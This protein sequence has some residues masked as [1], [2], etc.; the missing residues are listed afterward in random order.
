MSA[1]RQADV[2]IVGA[3]LA[4]LSAALEL[5]RHGRSVFVLEAQ[6]R[7]GGRVLSETRDGIVIDYGAQWISPHQKRIHALLQKYGLQAA[8]AYRAGNALFAL[9]GKQWLSRSDMPKLPLAARLDLYRLRRKLQ[10]M[11]GRI[12]PAAPWTAP[13]A[14]RLDAQ[15][16]EVWLAK[17]TLT[18]CG[19]AFV[20]VMAEEGLC[21]Q[22]SEVS[23]LDLLWNIA[24]A[25]GMERISTGE[26]AS[27]LGGAQTLPVRMAS[28]LG[29][30][31]RLGRPVRRI[32][33]DA[34]GVA[35]YTAQGEEW[36]GRAAIV[37]MP[38]T[39]A[40]R[41]EYDPPLPALRDQLCQRVGQGAVGKFIIV[42]ESPFWRERGMNGMAYSDAGPIIATMDCTAPGQSRGVLA[43][44]STGRRTRELGMMDEQGR[45]RE[46]LRCLSGFFG[47]EALRPVAFLEKDWTRDRWA[48]GGYGARF[49]P[50]VLTQY[51]SALID[52]VGPI[53]WAGS[54]TASEWR[55]YME[56]ALQSGERAAFEV[57]RRLAAAR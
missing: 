38:P 41:L 43:A 2:I 19:A 30:A 53:H 16:L 10:A 47:D 39:F 17:E 37:A 42:Y 57:L 50:G 11:A 21:G 26:D 1:I 12:D 34:D 45:E 36:S 49:A 54:E 5:H 3:G 48:R 14:Q 56:G 46:V 33:W 24:S 8:P 31:V 52:P 7:V 40:L 29:D 27:I 15:T 25:G 44:F 35:V 4:G 22:L 51:G 32:R 23:L 20:R 13:Q 6:S 18:S 55:L 28:E 9:Q